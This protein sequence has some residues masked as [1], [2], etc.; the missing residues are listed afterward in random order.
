VLIERLERMFPSMEF[1]FPA[2][3]FNNDEDCSPDSTISWA[4]FISELE[5]NGLHITNLK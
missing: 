2:E 5:D 4:D 1:F 3:T